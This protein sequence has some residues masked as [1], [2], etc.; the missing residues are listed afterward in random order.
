MMV[1]FVALGSKAALV[2][3]GGGYV[4]TKRHGNTLVLG[5]AIAL[6]GWYVIYTNKNAKGSPHNTSWHSWVGVTA[7]LSWVGLAM[8]G[9]LALHPDFGALKSQKTIRFA[10]KWGGR[11]ATG[12]GWLACFMGFAKTNPEP[13]HQFLFGAPLLAG[14]FFVLL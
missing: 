7:L 10:H 3:K 13:L 4:R 11:F 5:L 14:A 9:M 6:F 1:A 8:V 12:M 2:K